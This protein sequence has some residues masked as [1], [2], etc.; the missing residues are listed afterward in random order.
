MIR[1]GPR[2]LLLLV[3]AVVLV[4]TLDTVGWWRWNRARQLLAISPEAGARRLISDPWLTTPGAV[5]RS[6]RLAARDLAPASRETV[7]TVLG[8]LA[9]GRPD[10]SFESGAGIAA[11][12]PGG[13]RNRTPRSGSRQGPD[14]SIYPPP[15][16]PRPVVRGPTREGHPGSV[17]E[18]QIR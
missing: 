5:R 4:E 15:E 14:L 17:Q 2:L 8:T 10:R 13:K 7:I 3:A 11:P 12:G 1:T 18:R 9:P 6:R 16:G